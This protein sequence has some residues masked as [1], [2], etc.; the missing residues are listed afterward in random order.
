[1]ICPYCNLPTPKGRKHHGYCAHAE[2][3]RIKAR[4]GKDLGTIVGLEL[5]RYYVAQPKEIR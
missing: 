2:K 4:I 5:A 3:A 1:M